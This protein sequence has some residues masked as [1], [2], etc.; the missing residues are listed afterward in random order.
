MLFCYNIIVF[1]LSESLTDFHEGL[2]PSTD[3]HDNCAGQGNLNIA[4]PSV[5]SKFLAIKAMIIN[6]QVSI[7]VN[8]L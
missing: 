6:L 8:V 4:Y 1:R 3:P 7:I 5:V 2:S